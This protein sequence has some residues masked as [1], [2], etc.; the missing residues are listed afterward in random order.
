MEACCHVITASSSRPFSDLFFPFLS[1]NKTHK[2]N[3]TAYQMIFSNSMYSLCQNTDFI[4]YPEWDFRYARNL[5]N[6]Q[7]RT[8]TP[9]HPLT[10]PRWPTS[11]RIETEK[12]CKNRKELF[13][14][15]NVIEWKRSYLFCFSNTQGK[16]SASKNNPFRRILYQWQSCE[17]VKLNLYRLCALPVYTASVSGKDKSV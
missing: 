16:S 5:G 4:S 8:T 11:W 10:Q 15:E 2:K 3:H 7:P 1:L 6:G 9:K 14:P 17:A 13:P 12:K